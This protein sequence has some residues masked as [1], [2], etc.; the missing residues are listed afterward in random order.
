M[1]QV[2]IIDYGSGNLHSI[3]KAFEKEGKKKSFKVVVSDKAEDVLKASHIVLPGVGAFADCISGLEKL[4]GMKEALTQAVLIDKK[5]FL[6]VCVG[7]QMLADE[8]LENG[9]HKGL[10]WISGKV[11]PIEPKDKSL[12]IPHMGWNELNIEK[13]HPVLNGINSGDHVYFV[14][15]YHFE[16][17]DKANILSKVEYGASIVAII[18]NDNIVAAQFH[19]EKSQKTGLKFIAN[20]LDMEKS[21]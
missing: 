5:P 21:A 17:S 11:I 8:G 19:P 9:S 12:K 18:A 13:S 4:T 7:M 3:A 14:H 2:T 6:G 10:G 16:C 1:K 15:S 20:F